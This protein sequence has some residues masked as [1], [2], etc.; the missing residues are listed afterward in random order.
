MKDKP[1]VA[2]T[3]SSLYRW[4]D[5][6]VIEVAPCAM[7]LSVVLCPKVKLPLPTP[8]TAVPITIAS[9]F[10]APAAAAL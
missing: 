7:L 1:A 2:V 3:I 10:V 4:S 5:G 9:V 8:V 6:A